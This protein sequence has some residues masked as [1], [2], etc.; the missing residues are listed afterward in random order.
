MTPRLGFDML[1]FMKT[2]MYLYGNVWKERIEGIFNGARK[3]KLHP[4]SYADW[5]SRKLLREVIERFQPAGYI[6]ET[7]LSRVVKTL[8][9]RPDI[10]IVVCD[11][12]HILGLSGVLHDNRSTGV[13]AARFL[14][15]LKLASYAVVGIP[16]AKFPWTK[17]RE[18]AFCEELERL[19]HPVV[20]IDGRGQHHETGR[21]ML[22]ISACLRNLPKPCGIFAIQD[23]SAAS[24][25]YLSRQQG[26]RVPDDVIV[27]G[28]DNDR[29]ICE[30]TRPTLSSIQPDFT[31]S[32]ELAVELLVE[33][34]HDPGS[35][36]RTLEYPDVRVVTRKSTMRSR[37]DDK[38]ALAAKEFIRT[39]CKRRITGN[40]VARLMKC[41]RHTA[42]TLFTR[43]FGHS[44]S[45]ELL[46][47]RLACAREMLEHPDSRVADVA[48]KCGFANPLALNRAFKRRFGCA[49]K[50]WSLREG[51]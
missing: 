24:I 40:D 44:I 35:P 16:F 30:N 36:P 38:R 42:D 5:N 45:D 26:L 28:V 1:L 12:P 10:P 33:K 8:D 46:E 11:D 25:I 6:T 4:I 22:Q 21:W 3:H 15:R 31:H 23:E 34:I 13:M 2:I 20:R 41:S 48:E 49:P 9:R 32:G 37:T 51:R 27:L 50:A 47:A 43:A 19:G 39:N 14:A 7:G 29:L 17:P 18:D